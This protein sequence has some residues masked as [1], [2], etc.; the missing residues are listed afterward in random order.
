[1]KKAQPSSQSLYSHQK[2]VY[3]SVKFFGEYSKERGSNVL[4][5]RSFQFIFVWHCFQFVQEKNN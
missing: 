3:S 1:M 4:A 2:N 5:S